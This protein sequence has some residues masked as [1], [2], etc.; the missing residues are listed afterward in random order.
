MTLAD[1]VRE[2]QSRFTVITDKKMSGDWS[3]CETGDAFVSITNGGPKPEGDPWPTFH[4]TEDG[5]IE[6]WLREAIIYAD[7]KGSILHWREMP[8]VECFQPP[9]Q[10]I[11]YVVFSR[12]V[13][14]A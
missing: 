5:A 1:A 6:S 14:T 2:F 7:G 11:V 12:M 3:R 9:K 13:V 8:E 10:R 4:H